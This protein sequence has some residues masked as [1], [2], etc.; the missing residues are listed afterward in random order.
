MS[1]CRNLQSHSLDLKFDELMNLEWQ[2]SLRRPWPRLRRWWFVFPDLCIVFPELLPQHFLPRWSQ[3]HS[4]SKILG[5]VVLL[6]QR[7][8]RRWPITVDSLRP[9]SSPPYWDI[10]TK[11]GP[12]CNLQ[13]IVYSVCVAISYY[14]LWRQIKI[15][16]RGLFYIYITNFTPIL[17]VDTNKK[18]KERE[19][20]VGGK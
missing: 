12:V 18:K 20:K 6:R 2:L 5:C 4:P 9:R 10:L 16:T 3:W 1:L 15:R 11:L 13:C 7:I 17:W 19:T 8:W 14:S